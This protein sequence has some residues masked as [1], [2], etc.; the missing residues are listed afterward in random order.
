MAKKEETRDYVVEYEIKKRFQTSA[1]MNQKFSFKYENTTAKK[2]R[3]KFRTEGIYNK[4][5]IL[6]IIPA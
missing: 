2:I 3:Q 6:K 5:K 1:T 4:M